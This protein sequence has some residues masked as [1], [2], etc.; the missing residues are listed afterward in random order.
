[1]G[2][3]LPLELCFIGD[4]ADV[5]PEIEG[6]IKRVMEQTDQIN[7]NKLVG[8]HGIHSSVLR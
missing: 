4:S 3:F 6:A 5:M 8:L 7:S 2:E 1:M